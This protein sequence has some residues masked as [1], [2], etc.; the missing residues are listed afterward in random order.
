MSFHGIFFHTLTLSSRI[1]HELLSRFCFSSSE[2][3]WESDKAASDRL[4]F[5]IH[6]I[7]ECHGL[8]TLAQVL[9]FHSGGEFQCFVSL[10]GLGRF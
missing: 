6:V 2:N 7:L 4:S 10:S 9:T 1:L 5:A 8:C 3:S